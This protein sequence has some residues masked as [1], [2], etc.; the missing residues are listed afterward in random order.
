MMLLSLVRDY[1]IIPLPCV[2]R[3]NAEKQKLKN[4]VYMCLCIEYLVGTLGQD[5]RDSA[6]PATCLLR[7]Y[8][9]FLRIL[10]L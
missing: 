2:F 5:R 9:Y 1:P 3:D 4:R 7:R 8:S 6:A 10:G